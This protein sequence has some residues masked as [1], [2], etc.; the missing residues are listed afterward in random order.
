M[1]DTAP[2]PAVKA[3]TRRVFEAR[4]E[5]TY[6]K[7]PEKARVRLKENDM[8]RFYLDLPAGGVDPGDLPTIASFLQQCHAALGLDIQETT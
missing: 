6:T 8:G 2:A 5:D 1:N 3:T 4:L 7:F